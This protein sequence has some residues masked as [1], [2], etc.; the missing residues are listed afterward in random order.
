MKTGSKALV[1]V[2][3]LLICFIYARYYCL[4]NSQ[5]EI[6]QLSVN[7][8]SFEVLM[9]KLPIVLTE[10]IV[11]PNDLI[12]SAFKYLFLYN[13]KSN[14]V[15][16]DKWLRCNGRFLIIYNKGED[17]LVDIAHPIQENINEKRFISMALSKNQCM[18]LPTFWFYRHHNCNLE[19]N[20]L[21]SI[22]SAL[23][24]FTL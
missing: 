5:F 23:T 2:L 4:P 16:S 1:L 15:Q 9:E 24:W 7:N 8:L 12:K 10:K 6:L 11:N 19:I 3:A 18:V 21:Y 17:C 14:T 22:S 20:Q 13:S